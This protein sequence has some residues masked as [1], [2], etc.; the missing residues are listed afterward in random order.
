M[1]KHGPR[2]H[3]TRF[4]RFTLKVR[5]CARTNYYFAVNEQSAAPSFLSLLFSPSACLFSA[6]SMPGTGSA[7][8]G[9]SSDHVRC[10]TASLDHDRQSARVAGI[11]AQCVGRSAIDRSGG[12]SGVVGVRRDR[13]PASATTATAATTA[14]ERRARRRE[15]VPQSAAY[16]RKRPTGHGRIARPLPVQPLVLAGPGRR[17]GRRRGHDEE[18]AQNVCRHLRRHVKRITR[19]APLDGSR[20]RGNNRVT[21]AGV[22]ACRRRCCYRAIET[23]RKKG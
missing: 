7:S 4:F 12:Q 21:A 11:G 19:G 1:A 9:P 23:R 5:F 6:D 14:V 22:M 20:P 3:I 18:L 16:G 8:A 15:P 13:R 2:W 10:P 17:P